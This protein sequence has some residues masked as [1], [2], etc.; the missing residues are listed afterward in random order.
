MFPTLNLGP[1]VIS[2]Y[3][4]L[5]DI[6]IVCAL[7]WLWVRAPAH[8][9]APSRWLDAGLCAAVGGV[10]G[11]RLAFGIANWGYFQNHIIE[12][13]AFWEGGYAW[14]GA[15]AGALIGLWIYTWGR[16]E[17]LLPIL[18]ELA[19]PLVLLSALSW[20]GCAAAACAAGQDVPPGTLPFA[21]NG[22]DL[23]GVILPRWPTQIIGLVLSLIAFGYLA[24]QRNTKRPAGF[25][26][27]LAITLVSA[28][29]FVVSTVRGDDVQLISGWRVDA[30]ANAVM[31]V[32]GLIALVAAWALESNSSNKTSHREDAKDAK[33]IS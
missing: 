7:A 9:R 8:G 15:L 14:I 22:P 6:G 17:P 5:I 27:A 33:I 26:A 30:V 21:I 13:F 12:M 20:A 16:K 29:A 23:Y 2:T 1:I 31:T 10:V 32:V 4:L 18:D 25:N 28:I 3:T 24:S 11:G 19:L